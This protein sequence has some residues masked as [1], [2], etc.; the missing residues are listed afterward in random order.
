VSAS[1]LVDGLA[2]ELRRSP[3]R[4]TI[5]ITVDRDGSLILSAPMDCPTEL[6]E[7]AARKKQLWIH[8]KLAEKRLLAQP[9]KTKEFVTGEGFY[10]LGRSYRLLLEEVPSSDTDGPALRLHHGR[11]VLRCDE[12]YRAEEHFVDWYV[13]HGLPWIQR[14]IDFLSDRIGAAPS[15]VEVMDLGFRWGSCGRNRK[16]NF[17][18]RMIQLPP[19]IIEYIVVHELVHMHEPRHDRGFWRRLERAMPDFAARKRWL[20]ENGERFQG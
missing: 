7:Q 14:R 11:F 4:S 17:H 6:I 8:T 5:G 2:F 3:R 1:L 18:W 12:R 9:V 19:R 20:A 10:Y 15:G 16:L 13:R